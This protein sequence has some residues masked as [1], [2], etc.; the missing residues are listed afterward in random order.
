MRPAVCVS[1]HDVAPPTWPA[2]AS[3]LKML[4]A[5]GPIPVTLLLVPDYH[6]S[7]RFDYSPAF[8]RAI[9]ERIRRGDEVALHGYYHLD[10]ARTPRQPADWFR[11]R[12]LTAGEGEFAALDRD[13]ARLRLESGLALFASLG[14][15][16]GGFVAP[17]WLLG[18]GA[19]DALAGLPF[20][21]AT[22][23]RAIYRLPDWHRALAPSLVYSV[24][25]GWR[26][27]LSR[28]W[29]ARLFATQRHRPLLRISLHPVDARYQSVVAAW[30]LWIGIAMR[31][32]TAMTKLDWVDAA[33]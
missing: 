16:V 20:R 21:Y 10:E 1:L 15:P 6:R 12:V 31:D 22:T 14:W 7:G 28:A 11:R 30:R 13:R 32:R 19:R 24:R 33:W 3:L 5:L 17:A 29:N 25:S 26:R 4:D 8:R 18:R 27:G 23:Q 2:C 9:E